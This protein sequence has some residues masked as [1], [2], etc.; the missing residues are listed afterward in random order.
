MSILPDEVVDPPQVRVS[1]LQTRKADA[2][3]AL[4]VTKEFL[5][6]IASYTEEE[7]EAA[8]DLQKKLDLLKLLVN[9]ES[10]ENYV[11]KLEEQIKLLNEEINKGG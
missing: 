1:D 5:I 8:R 6:E 3:K 10:K 9:K 2:E 4:E 7:I 11:I